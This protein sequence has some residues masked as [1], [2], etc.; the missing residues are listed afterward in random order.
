MNGSGHGRTAVEERSVPG[1]LLILVA[2]SLWS[3]I[4]VCTRELAALG[5]TA[6]QVGAW[7]AL[8]GGACFV[9]HMVIGS[10]R[11]HR[12]PVVA[13]QR[14]EGR[15]GLSTGKPNRLGVV[16][17]YRSAITALC[18][19]CLVGVVVFYASLP[20]AVQTGGISLA[21]VLLYTAP[22][23]VSIG[24]AF[25]LGE[26]PGVAG[27]I[28]AAVSVGGVVALASTIGGSVE[29]TAVSIGWG[30]ASG[31]SYSSYYLVGRRLFETVGAVETYALVLP[32]GG[33]ALALIAGLEAP[34]PAMLPWLLLLGCGCTYLPYLAFGLGIQDTPSSRAVVLATVEPVLAILL[35]VALYGET[36]GIIGVV[37]GAVVLGSAVAAGWSR[38]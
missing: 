30:L 4:G 10:G 27:V 23:W 38:A 31:I 9:A 2:A 21:W 7:R 25:V 22:V 19:F 33:L 24:A 37:G 5:M 13:G 8:I 26:S 28:A 15:G 36:L 3:L 1:E 20:L 16:G 32:V 11:P 35:G 12:R 14:F 17:R 6:E 18:V 34:Q 29:V